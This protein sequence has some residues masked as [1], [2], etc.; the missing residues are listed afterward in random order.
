MCIAISPH[1]KYTY[2]EVCRGRPLPQTQ[3]P[4]ALHH[5][6]HATMGNPLPTRPPLTDTTK[7]QPPQKRHHTNPPHRHRPHRKTTPT[8]QP[9]STRSLEPA[10]TPTPSCLALGRRPIPQPHI[11]GPPSHSAR[12]LPPRRRLESG[13]TVL[14]VAVTFCLPHGSES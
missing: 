12:R 5:G 13:D 9:P 10:R 6:I 8:T 1:T 14:Q 7:L 4:R 3:T 2:S 11:H